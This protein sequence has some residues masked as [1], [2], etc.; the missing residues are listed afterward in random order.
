MQ[1]ALLETA[2]S[3]AVARLVGESFS[4]SSLRQTVARTW[5]SRLS[6]ALL[7]A[8]AL[9]VGLVAHGNVLCCRARGIPSARVELRAIATSMALLLQMGMSSRQSN[10]GGLATRFARS[11][12]GD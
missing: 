4:G 10:T 3:L 6:L 12:G 11:S 2:T 1:Q 8:I 7:L 5:L 9:Q